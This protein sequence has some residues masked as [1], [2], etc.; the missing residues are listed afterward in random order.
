MP[1]LDQCI[2]DASEAAWEEEFLPGT[3]NKNNCSGF[4]KAVAKRL[5]IPLPD[6]ANADGIADVVSKK[7][8]KVASG[9][10]AARLAGTGTW[11]SSSAVSSI[12]K[13]TPWCG[14]AASPVR[15]PRAARQSVRSGTVPT[16]TMWLT[17]PTASWRANDALSKW[18]GSA[19]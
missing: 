8:T 6:T 7:W 17:T 9:T 19:V 15:S 12:N 4:V 14:V 18:P 1:T 10:E 13:S 3:K 5:G 16:V 2:V 11:P